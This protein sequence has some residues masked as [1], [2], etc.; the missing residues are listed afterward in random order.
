MKLQHFG[1]THTWTQTACI[2]ALVLCAA[3]GV[4]RPDVSYAQAGNRYRT[5]HSF[6]GGTD[7]ASPQ[8]GLTIDANGNLYGTTPGGGTN[9][10]GVVFE[11]TAAGDEAV[12]YSFCSLDNCADGEAPRADLLLDNDGNLYG[13][14]S[15]GGVSPACTGCGTVF[16]LAPGGNETVLHAFA[17]GSDG[18]YP[19]AGLIRDDASN[20]YGTTYNGGLEQCP[21]NFDATGCGVVYMITS[22]GKENILYRFG[23][24]SDG[25][26]PYGGLLLDDLGNLDGTTQQGGPGC[27]GG[28][29]GYE[30]GCGVVFQITG[31]NAETIL[32]RF[33]SRLGI[34]PM[35]GLVADSAGDIYGTTSQGGANGD[36]T[37][38]ETTPAGKE[39][40]IYSFCSA[41]NCA[42]GAVPEA[43]VVVDIAGNL[44]GTTYWGGSENS[45]T[46]FKITPEGKETV[47]HSFCTE[48]GCADG[49][50]PLA[51]LVLDSAGNLWGTTSTGGANTLGTVFEIRTSLPG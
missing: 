26:W 43:G 25:A 33:G 19:I 6:E 47:L 38:Y 3:L 5:V 39:K 49:S 20:L 40:A 18:A 45:G 32:H 30:K 48:S 2:C 8:A 42:D 31:P 16:R 17:D 37:V 44:Y 27:Q 28:P 24:G 10:G 41:A 36:G 50:H 46:V 35:A 9:N 11:I 22:G 23:G 13:T 4:T 29:L 7:G 51:G 21:V 15:L 12:L 14:T 1:P 34:F